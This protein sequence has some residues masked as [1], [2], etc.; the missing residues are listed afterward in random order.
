MLRKRHRCCKDA[1]ALGDNWRNRRHH[2]DSSLGYKFIQRDPL[3]SK[4]IA[5]L[6]SR[7]VIAAEASW[8]GSPVGSCYVVAESE[9]TDGSVLLHRQAAE[10]RQAISYI[11]ILGRFRNGSLYG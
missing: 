8:E 3:L 9:N 7:A 10:R 1:A 5:E 6:S 11:Y 4:E 2:N